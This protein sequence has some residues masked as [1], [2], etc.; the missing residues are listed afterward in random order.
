MK[1]EKIVKFS[2]AFDKRDPLPHKN[3]GIGAV[4]CYMVLKG[5]NGAVHF[6]FSTGIFLPEIVEEYY[7]DKRDLFHYEYDGKGSQSYYMGF[8]VGYHSLKPLDKYQKE[9]EGRPCD[10]LDD[11]LCWGDGSAL[12]AEEWMDV[13]VRQGSDKIWEMLEEEYKSILE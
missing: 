4:K 11:R 1:F 10:W 12:R 5:E 13:L 7:K 6:V 3:Y 2:P 8:D 9:R